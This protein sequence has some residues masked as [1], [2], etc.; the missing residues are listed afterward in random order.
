M[1]KVQIN[2]SIAETETSYNNFEENYKRA[3][4]LHRRGL[5]SKQDYDAAQ[6]AWEMSK[7]RVDQT[8]ARVDETKVKEANVMAARAQ[9]K[10]ARAE[11]QLAQVKLN[12]SV[13]RAP[14]SGTVIERNVVAGQTVAASLASP[15]LVTIADLTAMKVD[16]WVDEAD[17]GTIKVG[18]EVEFSVDSY[19]TRLF[20]GKVVKI[21]PS[22]E[23]RQN[24]VTY[25][26]EIHVANDDLALKPGMTANVTIILA[27]KNEV[28]IVPHA[29]LKIQRSMLRNVYPEIEEGRNQNN[30]RRRSPEQRAVRA[31]KALQEGRGRLWVYRNGTPERVRIRFG[32]TDAKNM[33]ILSGLKEK[34]QVI[35][36]VRADVAAQQTSSSGGGSARRIRS[37]ILGGF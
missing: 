37:S 18:Q 33:E 16:A 9:V 36:G 32:A 10:R 15:P 1:Q 21:Y 13:I 29:A 26:T 23:I 34:D 3:A 28:L 6:T 4:E 11:L 8:S 35:V 24:V 17:I 25:D 12:R 19:P 2:A 7:A 27:R 31:R 14:V 22:P 5:I 30:R 20:N